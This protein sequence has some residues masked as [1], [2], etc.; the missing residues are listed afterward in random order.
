MLSGA[1]GEGGIREL[2]GKPGEGVLWKPG[3]AR[4]SRRGEVIKWVGGWTG[5][6]F[7]KAEVAGDLDKSRW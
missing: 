3:E 2:G 4:V 6:R 1:L 5:S 7:S